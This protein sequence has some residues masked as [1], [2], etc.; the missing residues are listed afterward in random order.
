MKATGIRFIVLFIVLTTSVK[1]QRDT[2]LSAVDTFHPKRF[3][4]ALASTS[5]VY[6]GSA[7]GLYFMWYKDIPS[8]SFHFF[9]DLNEW[10]QTDKYGH[11]YTAYIQS[12]MLTDMFRWTGIKPMPSAI[13]GS[14]VAF[15]T[16]STIE[17]FDGFS[18]KWGA[19]MSDIGANFIGSAFYL[20]QEFVFKKQIL[21][22]KYSITL[23][24][25]Q[26]PILKARSDDL[27]GT[28]I[29]QKVVKDY[30][31]STHWLCM[32]SSD[33]FP[34]SKCTKYIGIA[35]GFGSSGMF[36][37]M[38]NQWTDKKGVY[39]DRTDIERYRKFLL[40]PDIDFT[41]IKTHSK[42][43]KSLFYVLDFTK[44]PLPTLE[45]NTK[46]E[47]IFHPFYLMNFRK[48]F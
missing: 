1:A 37:G 34:H 4:T 42:V 7:T 28:N 48:E 35:I 11:I 8:T 9:N 16:S 40:S 19:S 20:G 31:G 43:L 14:S 21:K 10:N 13:L 23:N 15:V 47:F 38:S 39:H 33:I 45:Y 41:K 5:V 32:S 36:G 17:I 44:L 6:L 29:L 18:Q 12:K 27:Y 25:Y 2:L 3:N 30:N 26:D 24:T 46:G 22:L